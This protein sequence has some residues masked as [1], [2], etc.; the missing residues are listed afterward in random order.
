M[1]NSLFAGILLLHSTAVL[2]AQPTFKAGFKTYNTAMV[3]H[4]HTYTFL[5][6][7]HITL[8]DSAI[9]YVAT[10]SSVT[11]TEYFSNRDR[12]VYKTINYFSPKKQLLKSEDYKDDNLVEVNE[13]HYDDK[14][15]KST[16]TRENKMNN[17][18]YKHLYEYATDKKSGETVVTESSYFNGKIEFF[19]KSYYNSEHVKV[20][21][22][23]LNDNNKDVVHV[24]T[25]AYGENGKVKER[26]VF[27]PEFKVTK[28]FPEPAGQ[29]PSKCFGLLPSGASPKA[30]PV[31]KVT[32][33]KWV[34]NK[35]K[36]LLTDPGCKEYEYTFTGNSNYAI[37]IATTK[38]N[39]A[40]QVT[41]RVKEKL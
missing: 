15:R 30:N 22:T 12:S 8:T 36:A 4:E 11:M 20:K 21:E 24:E 34:Y 3:I 6:T 40:K 31:N 41:Y 16:H 13:W 33:I 37:T 26:T 7:A 39:N 14:N 29:I 5:D 38:V 35:N 9:T 23:R 19:T 32:F 28:K 1:K 10:D 27:F 17:N 2:C 18:H 25:Y